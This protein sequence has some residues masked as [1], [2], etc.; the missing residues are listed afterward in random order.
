MSQ[1]TIS[2][3]GQSIG[4]AG[5]IADS[6]PKDVV[7]GFN[8]N[9]TELPFGYGLRD[10]TARDFYGIATGFSTTVPVT[11]ILLRRA[12]YQPKI[13]L[14]NLQT[15]GDFGGSGLVQYAP[16][17]V[18]RKGRV[19]V[20]VEGAVTFGARA[21]CRGIATGTSAL[22]TPGIWSA[23]S[24]SVAGND[25]TPSYHVNTTRQAVFRSGSFTAADGS[26]QVAVLEVDFTNTAF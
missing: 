16:L 23:T 15:V 3:G 22:G 2:A 5:D 9:T 20:P 13:T 14:P 8:Q 26:T 12:N 18:M 7:S 4:D 19:L 17:N 24:Y 25:T 1:T 6:S 21:W 11:G 10:G